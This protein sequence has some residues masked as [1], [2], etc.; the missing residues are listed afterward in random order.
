MYLYKKF[1]I[2]VIK[3]IFLNILATSIYSAEIKN[4]ATVFMYHKFG[5][6]KYPSTSVT[7]S[8]LESH[9]NE[10]IKEKYNI[11]SLDFIVDTIINDGELPNNTIG[12]SIDD[13]DKSFFDVGWPLFKKNNIPVTLFVTTKT[14]SKNNKNYLN[15]DQ[16]RKLKEE[17]VVIGAHSH[18]HAHMPDISIDEVK[19]EIEISNKIFLK[20]LGEIP[21]LFAF[22]YGET[23]TEIIELV[24]EYKFKVAFGQHSGIINET[25]NMYYL[26]RFSLNEKY[27]ELDRVKFATSAQGLG[28]YDFIPENPT[29][30]QNPPFIGFSLLDNKKVQGLDC[31]IFDSKGQVER[32]IFKFNE[33][34]EIRLGRELSTGRSRMNCT[35]KDSSG[36]WR[37]FGH[38]FYF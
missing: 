19:K 23:T 18:T 10:F 27:G 2:I 29:I 38:Q 28:V 17:G 12:I 7:I 5:V 6:D 35:V 37:W 13:A 14:I 11:K 33:R 25:S 31:F 32:E 3:T 30:D 15:W 4:S 26:P 16:I 36:V 20:E 21:T 8:Q 24:K 9:I 1:L 22:P 34:V